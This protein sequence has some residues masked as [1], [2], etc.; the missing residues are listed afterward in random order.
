MCDRVTPESAGPAHGSP[1]VATALSFSLARGLHLAVS[2]SGE[3]IARV[4][5]ITT[6]PF[7]QITGTLKVLAHP[8]RLRLLLMLRSGGSISTSG[9][10]CFAPAAP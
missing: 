9:R 6:D 7:A 2:E 1:P 4:D 10:S 5:C 3:M 8:A